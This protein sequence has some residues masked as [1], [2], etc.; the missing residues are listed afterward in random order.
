MSRLIIDRSRLRRRSPTLLHAPPPPPPL[1]ACT[2]IY[3]PRGPAWEYAPLACGPYRGCGHACV[4]CYIPEGTLDISREEFDAGAHDRAAFRLGLRREAGLLQAAGITGQALL[5]FTSDPYHPFDTSLTRETVEVLIERGFAIC[6]LTKAGLLRVVRDIDLYRADKDCFAVTLISMDDD[7][8][9]HWERNAPL[10]ADRI[11]ALRKFHD[12][13]I[14]VWVSLEPI[15]DIDHTIAVIRA[16]HDFVDHYKFGKINHYPKLENQPWRD[17]T[18][19]VCDELHRYDKS[20]YVK[21]DL[22]M[23]LP[24]GYFNP[25]RIPQHH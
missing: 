22:Q 9:H 5:S 13:G 25:M 20:H 19:R 7:F 14:Y 18:L 3:Q 11:A 17:H 23:Y 16:T 8:C 15:I 4:Y 12:A 10:P 2:C 21:A 6:I 1:N 24:D